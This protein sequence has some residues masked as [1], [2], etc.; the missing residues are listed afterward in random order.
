MPASPNASPP[1]ALRIYRKATFDQRKEI[2]GR[3]RLRTMTYIQVGGCTGLSA[4]WIEQRLWFPR[5]PASARLA[6]LNT[7]AAWTR[8]DQMANRFN[9]G[10]PTK[11][12][13]VAGIVPNMPGKRRGDRVFI[14]GE[15]DFADLRGALK[16]KPGYYVVELEFKDG[17]P[18]HLCALYNGGV[19]LDFFDPNS[20]EYFLPESFA[21]RFFRDLRAHYV[22]YVDA[23]G[24]AAPKRF[25][26][27]WLY[28][29]GV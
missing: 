17:G 11:R 14:D 10:P 26:N 22:E 25:D 18:S 28:P 7:D 23:S 8:I 27:L 2:L 21:A 15:G 9:N 4:S 13:R 19:G 1:L 6:N 5:A 29:V 20:G 12:E 3:D 24:Q 16:D